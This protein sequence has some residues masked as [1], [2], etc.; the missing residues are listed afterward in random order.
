MSVECTTEDSKSEDENGKSVSLRVD[1]QA[2]KQES[3]NA[4]MAEDGLHLEIRSIAR[5]RIQ[6]ARVA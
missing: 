6:S 1:Q 5:I 2:H 3:A 4:D